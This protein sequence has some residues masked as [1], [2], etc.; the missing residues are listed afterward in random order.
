MRKT[1]FCFEYFSSGS[2]V[3]VLQKAIQAREDIKK[4]NEGMARTAI[5]RIFEI[6]AACDM[7]AKIGVVARGA[8]GSEGNSRNMVSRLVLEA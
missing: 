2:G 3:E 6:V 7:M 8:V 1:T 4:N 5:G